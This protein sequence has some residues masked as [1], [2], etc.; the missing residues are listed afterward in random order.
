MDWMLAGGI[1]LLGAAAG[2][3]FG[4]ATLQLGDGLDAQNAVSD[5]EDGE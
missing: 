3:W 1:F 4:D 5:D 2:L